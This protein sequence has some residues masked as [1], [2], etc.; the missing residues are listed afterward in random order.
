MMQG[1][2]LSNYFEGK[3]ILITGATS[4]I[5]RSLTY[6]Y[7][8]K[9]AKVAL[10][11]NQDEQELAKIAHEFPQTALSLRGD[12]THDSFLKKIKEEI[13]NVFGGLDILI[14]C[15]GK[16]IIVVAFEVLSELESLISSLLLCDNIE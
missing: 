7:L 13:I 15:A 10:V 8:N 12:L 5:G 9:G 2:T 11:G 4:G 16:S 1:R 14:N 6:W 3:K